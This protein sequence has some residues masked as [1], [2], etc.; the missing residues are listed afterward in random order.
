VDVGTTSTVERR[1][2]P[3]SELFVGTGEG[4]DNIH[5]TKMFPLDAVSGSLA[6]VVFSLQTSNG[7]IGHLNMVQRALSALAVLINLSSVSATYGTSAV[8]LLGY[9]SFVG[10]TIDQTLTKK[11][12]PAPVDAWLGI[13]Y[14]SQPIG[15]ARFAPVGPPE[16]FSGVKNAAQYGYSCLQDP[17][18]ITYEMNEACLA[19]RLGWIRCR[20]R[21]K[22][23]RCFLRG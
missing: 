18:D 12:L 9:G 22:F 8:T 6:N 19:D 7:A 10:T 13:D 4:K 5:V 2:R 3:T 1:V 16:P 14:A 15:E 20:Q 23:R 11:P 17:L 21:K